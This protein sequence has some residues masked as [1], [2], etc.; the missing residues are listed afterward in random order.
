MSKWYSH[1]NTDQVLT[2][3]ICQVI[4]TQITRLA[5]SCLDRV[6]TLIEIPM[7]NPTVQTGVEI[8]LPQIVRIH[9]G[10]INLLPEIFIRPLPDV[11]VSVLTGRV[12]L[13]PPEFFTPPES[14]EQVFFTPP[15]SQNLKF[16]D[17]I[18]GFTLCSSIPCWSVYL[19][20][21]AKPYYVK[22]RKIQHRITLS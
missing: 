18:L 2:A 14:L 7:I 6:L 5:L 19:F 21:T 9:V 4:S 16:Y 3:T 15:E 13:L 1:F 12:L 20:I 8:S 10:R 11:H 17:I 22:H